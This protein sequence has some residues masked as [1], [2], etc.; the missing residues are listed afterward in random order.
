MGGRLSLFLP[1]WRSITSSKWVLS[2]IKNGYRIPLLSPPPITTSRRLHNPPPRSE[3]SVIELEVKALLHKKAICE[4]HEPGHHSRLFCIPKKTGDLRPVLNLK[5]LNAFL[6][7]IHFKMETL[8]SICH[9]LKPNDFL[10]SIDLRDAFL[11]V[12]IHAQSQKYLQ[13]VWRGKKY[14]FR[15]LPFGLSLSPLVF[16]KILKPLLTWARKL[17]IRVVAYL[18]DLLIMAS[19]RQES[20]NHTALFRQKLEEIGFLVKESKSTLIPTQS[21]SHLGFNINT[22]DMTLSI[23]GSKLRDLRRSAKKLLSKDEAPLRTVAAFIGQAMSL[24][25]AVFPA[26]LHL[27]HLMQVQN[28]TLAMKKTWKSMTSLSSDAKTE[29]EWWI[30]HLQDWNGKSFVPQ[31][32]DL[33]LYT[34]SSD[35]HWGIVHDSNTLSGSWTE[36][37]TTQHI[38]VKELLVVEHALHLPEVQGKTANII[39]DNTTTI[40]YLN[41]FGGTKSPQLREVAIRIWQFCLDTGTR[42]RT[43]YVP[44]TLNPADAPSR[45]MNTQL[46]W[47]ISHDFFQTLNQKWGPHSID[48]FAS[49]INNKLPIFYSWKPHP[50]AASYDALSRSWTDLGNLYLCPPWNL[51]STALQKIQ[52]EGL[53]ATII[54]PFWPTAYWFPTIKRMATDPPVPVPRTAVIP[55]PGDSSTLLEKNPHWSM[56]AWRVNGKT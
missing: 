55:A 25:P 7:K 24:T 12:P 32:S 33:D 29:L 39:C 2:I 13:F 52:D 45:K 4:S 14:C 43:T 5:P 8:K 47:G 23:P 31:P 20:L 30:N 48:L 42:I 16:T 50:Q 56:T 19:S 28:Q 11:H 53:T 21:I 9:L 15:T 36:T 3:Q 40:S 38:N 1:A 10:T 27:Q 17:G 54:T 6:P 46:E 37:E 44:S 34:D 51:I 22:T 26:R 49:H 35:L 41:R 18:D